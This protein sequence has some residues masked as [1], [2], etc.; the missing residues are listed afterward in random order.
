MNAQK[1]FELKDS[2]VPYEIK[3]KMKKI[4]KLKTSEFKLKYPNNWYKYGAHGY[5]YLTPKDVVENKLN[6]ELN[7]LSVN[8]NVLGIN[9]SITSEEAL[10]IHA[11]K[12]RS[13]EKNVDYSIK[14]IN[15]QSNYIYKIEYTKSYN[16]IPYYFKRIE[17]FYKS[18]SQLK[19][20]KFQMREEL[21]PI[22]INEAMLII[23]SFQPR[24]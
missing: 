12:V 3:H 5:I 6:N 15:S 22:Y 8:K 7:F 20:V 14:K 13:F 24:K 9:D 10:Q 1:S 19:F 23:D 11:N 21:F 2:I 4:K 18:K 16:N 17:Y